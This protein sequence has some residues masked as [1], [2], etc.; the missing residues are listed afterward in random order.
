[1]AV[2]YEIDL[3]HQHGVPTSFVVSTHLLPYRWTASIVQKS[4]HI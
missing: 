4:K 1:M 3:S 2:V